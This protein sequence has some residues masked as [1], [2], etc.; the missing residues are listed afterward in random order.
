MRGVPIDAGATVP[1]SD[2][3]TTSLPAKHDASRLR[4]WFPIALVAT[5]WAFIYVNQNFEFSAVGRFISRM[6]ALLLF[7]LTFTVWWLTRSVFTWRDRFLAI[8]VVVA[9]SAVA[10][11]VADKS[12]S[13]FGFFLMPDR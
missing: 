8:G 5:Y 11:L 2:V 12:M 9:V 10:V 3:A 6:I 7:F 13:A 1:N 4:L